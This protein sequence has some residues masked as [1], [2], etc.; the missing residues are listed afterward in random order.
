MGFMR[1]IRG[2]GQGRHQNVRYDDVEQLLMQV[3]ILSAFLL[4]ISLPMEHECLPGKMDN[5]DFFGLIGKNGHFREYVVEVIEASDQD[6]NW[7]IAGPW[8]RLRRCKA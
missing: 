4:S 3:G 7:T 5:S 6:F 2:F 1:R 8:W